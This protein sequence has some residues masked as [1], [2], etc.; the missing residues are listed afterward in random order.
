MTRSHLLGYVAAAAT[1]AVAVL[2]ALA[3][4]PLLE[5]SPFPIF[6]AA[7]TLSA[8]RGGMGPGLVATVLGVAALDFLFFQPTYTLVV[9]YASDAVNLAV[10]AL[11]ALLISSLNARLRSARERADQA[12]SEAERLAAERAA[13]L[14][15]IA[16]GVVIADPA[17][18]VVFVNGAARRMHG[19]DRA[20][21]PSGYL[22]QAVFV[23]PDGRRRP[24]DDLPLT[25]A[26]RLGRPTADSALRLRRPD[27]S[28]LAVEAVATP[29]VAEDNT[30][31]GTVMLLHDVTTRHELERQRDEFLANVSHDLRTP[32][33]AI[34]HSIEV[35]LA[36]EP[37]ATPRPLHE[38]FVNIDQATARMAALVDDLLALSRLQAGKVR[39][40]SASCDLAELA[41]GVIRGIEPLAAA[42]RQLLELDR[43]SK[44]VTIDAD[45]ERL[46]QALLNLVSN[47]HKYG[48]PGGTIRVGVAER[49]GHALLS[50]ADDGPGIP[51]A[52][53]ERIFERFYRA[54]G[55]AT[56][57]SPGS[58]L[59]LPIARALVELH[60]GRVWVES[61]PGAGAT[62][63]VALPLRGTASAE[64]LP[65]GAPA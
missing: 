31:V 45:A 53:H 21:A 57:G 19:W 10:F 55:E 4:T 6:L 41:A 18:R 3:L 9:H 43:P 8:W 12:R 36:N 22:E 16:D 48:R 54:E 28:H 24:P 51:E 65:M 13:I 26:S 59:G 46:G 64:R 49:D 58:G 40:H 33:T 37:R 62:F 30:R 14:G 50:V 63:H 20:S 15:Q 38:L 2:C 61:E 44:P 25:R 11:V 5:V 42:R 39:L 52:E 23:G 60:G 17:D 1:S 34:K 35:V 27:G 29:V 56:R 32:L 7:V 47:A